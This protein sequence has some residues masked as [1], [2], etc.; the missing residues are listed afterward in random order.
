MA[1]ELRFISIL[2]FLLSLSHQRNEEL[3]VSVI[4]NTLLCVSIIQ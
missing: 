3:S 2:S 1:L 4:R